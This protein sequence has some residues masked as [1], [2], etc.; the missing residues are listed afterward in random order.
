MGINSLWG[1]LKGFSTHGHLRQFQGQRVAVDTYVWLHSAASVC[2]V[3]LHVKAF[4]RYCEAQEEK[5][6][7]KQKETLDAT[8]EER[9]EEGKKK[10]IKKETSATQEEAARSDDE[11][12]T[13]DEEFDREQQGREE[14]SSSSMDRRSD[15]TSSQHETSASDEE[16]T[17]IRERKRRRSEAAAN[18]TAS[19]EGDGEAVPPPL[20]PLDHD[21]DANDTSND[22]DL[23]QWRREIIRMNTA[24]LDYVVKRIDYLLSFGIIPICVFDGRP[25]PLKK[26]TNHK[27]R[28]QRERHFLHAMAL[29][30]PYKCQIASA[31]AEAQHMRREEKRRWRK[32]QEEKKNAEEEKGRGL[33]GPGEHHPPTTTIIKKEKD[34]DEENNKK[35]VEEEEDEEEKEDPFLFDVFSYL[36]SEGLK[37]SVSEAISKA[38]D[39]TTELAAVV[40]TVLKEARHIECIVAPYEADSQM[41]YLCQMGYVSA[42]LS[43]DS[44][45][46]AYF[47]PQI[48]A[49]T[50]GSGNG[51]CEVLRPPVVCPLLFDDVVVKK[52]DAKK[53]SSPAAMS[54]GSPR[55][56]SMPSSTAGSIRKEGREG[57]EDGGLSFSYDRFLLACIMAGCDYLPNLSCIGFKKAY[58]LLSRCQSM[59]ELSSTLIHEFHFGA[60][61]VRV[62][63]QNLYKAYY[64]FQFHIVYCP[65]A[66]ALRYY[67]SGTGV[68]TDLS[69]EVDPPHPIKT[70]TEEEEEE[71]EV[72]PREPCH[73]KNDSSSSP[74]L[75]SSSLPSPA[76][77]SLAVSHDSRDA[78]ADIATLPSSP[79]SSSASALSNRPRSSS[80]LR[81]LR[82]VVGEVWERNVA[83]ETCEFGIR[84]P[85]TLQPYRPIYDRSL[86]QPY[87]RATRR[88][89]RSLTSFDAFAGQKCD[90]V[91]C[92][93]GAVGRRSGGGG[94]PP[95]SSSSSLVAASS[96]ALPP[97]KSTTTTREEEETAKP[98]NGGGDGGYCGRPPLPYARRVQQPTMAMV[99]SRFF[100]RPHSATGPEGGW[101][102]RSAQWLS[103]LEEEEEVEEEEALVAGRG[104][105]AVQE[106]TAEGCPSP[107][108]SWSSASFLS[109]SGDGEGMGAEPLP[110]LQGSGGSGGITHVVHRDG[111]APPRHRTAKPPHDGTPPKKVEAEEAEVDTT[112]A[113]SC[114]SGGTVEEDTHD[115]DEEEEEILYSQES[116][117]TISFSQLRAPATRKMVHGSSL[118][119]PAA[120]AA[121]QD[122]EEGEKKE[123][124]PTPTRNEEERCRTA[125]GCTTTATPPSSS[126]SLLPTATNERVPLSLDLFKKMTFSGGSSR[127]SRPARTKG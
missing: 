17:R 125:E 5:A 55:F 53:K 105:S 108:A 6:R 43:E 86:L 7:K 21:K 52:L 97:L 110:L 58:L 114:G 36:R 28:V 29:L 62:Y 98:N 76:L 100:V 90:A 73:P 124:K 74:S 35:I 31:F 9:E 59:R 1:V 25:M 69:G 70:K 88:G 103:K 82:E 96:S 60:E 8:E 42:C 11:C 95:L 109:S 40:M 102:A 2:G 44:D 112:L 93:E 117:K 23:T 48:I 37:K 64:A 67:T 119:S 84:D 63:M 51:S 104:R 47:C 78:A 87:W 12:G 106:E 115:D 99:R 83:M 68:P 34:D 85:V 46:I 22:E 89:Q 20:H 118:S 24:F 66:K 33:R 50:R 122:E 61:V 4:L 101:A 111:A 126:S 54:I 19:G 27:R 14:A 3:S 56:A 120:A 91:V 39:I 92:R 107:S 81:A 80:F 72:T 13:E 116:R 71:T 30:M 65:K 45:L 15:A 10:K 113:S 77:S 94:D 127:Y 26:E 75:S 79:P 18:S 16:K 41:S 57:V 38:F 123:W 49:K 32:K 121:T